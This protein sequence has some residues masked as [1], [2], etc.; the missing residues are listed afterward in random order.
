MEEDSSISSHI[1]LY[2]SQRE[3]WL[4]LL[5]HRRTSTD[6]KVTL[7]ALLC[8][9]FCLQQVQ[10]FP[11]HCCEY[12]FRCYHSNSLL[13]CLIL[14]Y[15][16]P[17]FRKRV[18]CWSFTL[19][20]VASFCDEKK[21]RNFVRRFFLLYLSIAFY[22]DLLKKRLDSCDPFFLWHF[23]YPTSLLLVIQNVLL[24]HFF[25]FCQ[26]LYQPLVSLDRF[27]SS[28]LPVR[29]NIFFPLCSKAFPQIQPRD[30]F[31]L[32]FE[33]RNKSSLRIHFSLHFPFELSKIC[34]T[35]FVYRLR[36]KV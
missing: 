29:F 25:S 13:Y 14:C 4:Q 11:W 3:N 32:S 18:K 34:I 27:S 19:F 6:W 1:I 36:S 9:Q 12:S 8:N 23:F 28:L 2:W 20:F 5:F 24:Y 17:S 33:P 26:F 10:Q 22:F 30:V 7:Q 31:L 35:S 16:R 21:S 15:L